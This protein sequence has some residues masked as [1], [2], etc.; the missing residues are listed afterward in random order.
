MEKAGYQRIVFYDKE[1]DFKKGN[2]NYEMGI[3][4]IHKTY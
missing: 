2:K 4:H 1:N 3:G